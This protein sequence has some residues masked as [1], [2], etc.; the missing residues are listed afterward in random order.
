MWYNSLSLRSL[1]YIVARVGIIWYICMITSHVLHQRAKRGIR[2]FAKH[3]HRNR[4]CG[5]QNNKSRSLCFFGSVCP[6]EHFWQRGVQPKWEA[7]NVSREQQ[8][9]NTKAWQKLTKCIPVL[10]NLIQCI[11][12][13][14][15]VS[16]GGLRCGTYCAVAKL[17][18]QNILSCQEETWK[19]YVDW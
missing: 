15:N 17:N 19:T 7:A 18:G 5:D 10:P 3:S 13:N 8:R 12:R 14:L 1:R 2:R 9:S 4:A 6:C 16:H 11:H